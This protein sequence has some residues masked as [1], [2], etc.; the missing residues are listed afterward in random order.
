MKNAKDGRRVRLNSTGSSAVA[1]NPDWT[2][3]TF[4][5]DSVFGF[6]RCE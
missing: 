2:R 1:S 4:E 3:C 5:E 6:A